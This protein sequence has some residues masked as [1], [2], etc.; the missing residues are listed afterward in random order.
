MEGKPPHPGPID[1]AA[2]PV[3]SSKS[4]W[5]L[6][7]G[8]FTSPTY[9]FTEYCKKPAIIVPL[10]IVLVMVGLTGALTAKQGAMTQYDLMKHSTVIPQEI[11]ETMYQEALDTG[12]FNVRGFIGTMVGYVLVSL[13]IALI[14]WFL[15]S[16]VFGGEAKFKLVW[17]TSIM[18][19]LISS[20][21]GLLKVPLVLAKDTAYVSLGPAAFLPVK[22]FASVLFSLLF[23]LDFFAIWAI[24]VTGIG[25]GIA[26]GIS[27]GKGIAICSIITLIGI[28][29]LVAGTV[30]GLSFAG[31]EVSFI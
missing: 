14:A 12:S 2:T 5:S 6:M 22:S 8:V 11:L 10:F 9:T 7:V 4:I 15:G 25:F 23:Y 1:Q 26:F 30:L 29:L 16:F 18:G 31:V 24:I 20:L 17:G 21:G 3:G 28:G 13:I 27:Q 19:A